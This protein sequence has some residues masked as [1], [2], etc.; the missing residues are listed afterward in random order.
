MPLPLRIRS[1]EEDYN[2]MR[3]MFFAERPSFAEVLRIL[4][5]WEQQFNQGA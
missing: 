5:E 2:T 3:E 4:G 1:L